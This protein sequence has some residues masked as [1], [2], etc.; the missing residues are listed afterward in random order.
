MYIETMKNMLQKIPVGIPKSLS[1]K[2]KIQSLLHD[3]GGDWYM[4]KLNDNFP[5]PK[6]RKLNKKAQEK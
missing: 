1:Y 6:K 5:H 2:E 4:N 3:V